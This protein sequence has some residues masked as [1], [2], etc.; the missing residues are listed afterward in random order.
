MSRIICHL[1][2]ISTVI[3]CAGKILTCPRTVIC[4][5]MSFVFAFVLTDL[6]EQ[7]IYSAIFEALFCYVP[8]Q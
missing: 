7:V 3:D 1:V 4:L 8:V 6:F 2:S 5:K